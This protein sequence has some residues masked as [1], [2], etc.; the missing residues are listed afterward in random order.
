MKLVERLSMMI[1][2]K[3]ILLYSIDYPYLVTVL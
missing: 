1:T 2:M 3:T